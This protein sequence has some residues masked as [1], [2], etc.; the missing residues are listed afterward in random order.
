LDFSSSLWAT[1]CFA[2]AFLN[3]K[4]LVCHPEN[5]AVFSYN[6]L[7]V[8]DLTA[9]IYDIPVMKPLEITTNPTLQYMS[10]RD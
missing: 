10:E 8:Q 2:N 1:K 7:K 3:K 6:D 9:A 4:I 5:K